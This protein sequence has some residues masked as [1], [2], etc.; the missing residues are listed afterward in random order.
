M[1]Q[2]Q[3]LRIGNLL[4][5]SNENIVVVESIN[6]EGINI[7]FNPNKGHECIECYYNWYGLQPIPITEE[8]LLEFGAVKYNISQFYLDLKHKM[9]LT[10]TLQLFWN[11]GDD[12]FICE[13]SS[14]STHV[15]YFN[16]VKYIHQL[17]NLIFYLTGKELTYSD[18]I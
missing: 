9:D 10:H 13:F 14:R 7:F 6:K 2:A 11:I 18:V 3:E 5:D 4:Y 8:R 16:D 15:C 12:Y 17:Q 1:I